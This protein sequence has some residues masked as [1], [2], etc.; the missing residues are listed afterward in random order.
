MVF[1]PVNMQQKPGPRDKDTS[2]QPHPDPNLITIGKVIKAFGLKGQVMVES[3]TEFPDRFAPNSAVLIRGRRYTISKS[4]SNR[5]RWTLKLEGIDHLDEARKL[6]G[7]LLQIEASDLRPL[8][9]GEYYRFQIL[10]LEVVTPS[11]SPWAGSPTSCRPAPTMFTS[12]PGGGRS[13]WCRPCRTSSGKWT[14]GRGR[15]W[16]SCPKG[17]P[18][19]PR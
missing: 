16:W 6:R 8:P 11:G 13:A 14:W 10:G 15:W 18:D 5:G 9:Q 17:C 12:S 4:R 7:E 19:W 1:I 3:L 2:P